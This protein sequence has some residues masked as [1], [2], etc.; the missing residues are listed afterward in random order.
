[1]E[2]DDLPALR[3]LGF[4]DDELKELGLWIPAVGAPAD[5]AEM[6]VRR[7]KKKDSL[8]ALKEQ[9]RRMCGHAEREGKTI[10]HVWFEQVSAS[11]SYVRREEFEKATAALAEARLSK[12]LYVYKISRL[13][14]RGAGQ[15]GLLLDE[16]EDLQARIYVVAENI[17]S[18]RARSMLTFLSDQ[19]RE[20][21]ADLSQFVKL[22][23]DAGKAE[24]KWTGGVTPFGLRSAGGKLEH[25]PTEYLLARRIAVYLL[26]RKTPNW[27]ANTLNTEAKLTRHGKKWSGPGIISLAH[28]VTWAGLVAQRE[29]QLDAKGKWNGK[30]HRGGS[31]LMDKNGH[32]ISCGEG[33]ITFAEHVKIKSIL[34]SR[35]QKGTSIGDRTRGKREIVALLSASLH[36]G[37]CSGPMANGGPNYRCYARQTEGESSCQGVATDRTRIDSAVETLWINHV[38][39]LSPESDTLHA[40]AKE[41]L[42]YKDPAKE[43]RK[44]QV[45]AALE[46]AVGRQMGLNKERWV[47]GRMSEADYEY[48]M[49]ELS[50]QIDAH[51]AELAT[52]SIDGDLSPLMDPEA[53]TALWNGAGIGGQRAL[54]KAALTEE[55]I[56]LAAPRYRGDR[57]PILDRLTVH[58][59]DE[60]DPA[61]LAVMDAGVERVERT[62]QRQ[63]T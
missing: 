40:I 63:T 25:D 39:S 7:S 38:L 44:I 14:R 49:S 28:A 50:A 20:Q 55:G 18:T 8:S 24:G 31:P 56:T 62:R 57:T 58:W 9:V 42:S 51:K 48:L 37:R 27:I 45:S 29:R 4:D 1:M 30:Y 46:S 26:D 22:G 2:R 60:S 33:V 19:A 53:V 16:L 52:L 11:K 61:A 59:R 6:Y 41:W 32:P 47:I 10:R 3:A 12:T 54:L 21:V 43:A 5:L 13:S 15:V 34:A 23:M 17:D 36:C 35:S